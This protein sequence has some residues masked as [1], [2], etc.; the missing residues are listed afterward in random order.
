MGPLIGIVVVLHFLG[1]AAILGGWLAVRLGA[2]KGRLVL[3]W[4]ARAQLLIG[5]VLVGLLELMQADLTMAKIAVK[6]VVALGVVASAEIAN[7]RQSK[8]K[9]API[10]LDVAAALAVLNILVAVLWRTES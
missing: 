4:G 3:V 7:A 2:E 1:L 8:G 9:N 5:V 6:L 10:L